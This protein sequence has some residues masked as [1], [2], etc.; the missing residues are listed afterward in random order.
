MQKKLLNLF[1]ITL[2]F[3][4][5]NV[6]ATDNCDEQL[7]TCFKKM[8]ST[9]S[10]EF[11]QDIINTITHKY[12][13]GTKQ[14]Y[15]EKIKAQ[16][17]YSDAI[18]IFKSAISKSPKNYASIIVENMKLHTECTNFL[19]NCATTPP[20]TLNHQYVTINKK[21]CKINI[22]IS[23]K[24]STILSITGTPTWLQEELKNTNTVA[25]I[26]E[27]IS[28]VDFCTF[29]Y[30]MQDGR[31]VA[32]RKYPTYTISLC[33][34][35]DKWYNSQTTKSAEEYHAYMKQREKLNK[36]ILEWTI[37]LTNPSNA[38]YAK[39]FPYNSNVS[40]FTMSV[41]SQQISCIK[42]EG[43]GNETQVTSNNCA[44]EFA[45]R[46]IL[47]QIPTIKPN[48]LVCDLSARYIGNDNYIKCYVQGSETGNYFFWI[49]FDDTTHEI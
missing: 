11:M 19:K 2:F 4:P 18:N 46:Y 7:K 22:P 13:P 25:A 29:G 14:T 48:Y 32:L 34:Q 37:D 20:Y 43:S 17:N 42:Y 15:H 28:P 35:Y 1:L 33:D 3:I 39:I 30:E 36:Q 31:R 49:Q 5:F 10:N 23:L 16:T 6:F 40:N 12:M 26:V 8:N 45:K 27:A 24:E 44:A 41:G 21:L 9:N 38:D 47:D